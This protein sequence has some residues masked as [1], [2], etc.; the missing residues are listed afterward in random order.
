MEGPG[1]NITGTKVNSYSQS[2]SRFV[3]QTA[4]YCING[5]WLSCSPHTF[6]EDKVIQ[7]GEKHQKLVSLWYGRDWTKTLMT[8]SDARDKDG[9]ALLSFSK[10]AEL[11]RPGRLKHQVTDK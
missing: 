2:C 9:L 4:K 11:V 8:R 3:G 1:K 5:E 7:P 10:F 6:E